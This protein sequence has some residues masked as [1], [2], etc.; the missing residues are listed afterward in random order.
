MLRR[1]KR[2]KEKAREEPKVL[3]IKAE[4]ILRLLDNR[5]SD[6]QWV[7][8]PELIVS[9]AVDSE[10]YENSDARMD[11]WAMNIW[12]S[13]NFVRVCYE[14]KISRHDWK[15][16]LRHPSKRRPGLKLSNQFY[17]VMPDG[18]ARIEEVPKECGLLV[19]K[20]PAGKNYYALVNR[21]VAPVR[22]VEDPPIEF[23]AS[24]ARRLARKEGTYQDDFV[25]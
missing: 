13:R 25:R 16:E 1:R 3:N 8:F 2:K 23:W 22:E 7:F 4:D 12:E 10:T 11:A 24:L 15:R 9:T 21:K 6:R 18:C 17:Y 20:K 5:H 19:V 14:I